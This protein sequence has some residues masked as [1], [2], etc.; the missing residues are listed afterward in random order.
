MIT[1][2]SLGHV[3]SQEEQFYLLGNQIIHE[4]IFLDFLY[5]FSRKKG[6]KVKPFFLLSR[7]MNITFLFPL[8]EEKSQLQQ[9]N[10][11]KAIGDVNL[12]LHMVVYKNI[13]LKKKSLNLFT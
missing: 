1:S 11:R 5:I 13:F 8:A 4:F 12:C 2:D 3:D 9:K 6:G 10:F 7:E